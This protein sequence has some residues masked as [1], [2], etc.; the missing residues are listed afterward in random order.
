MRST[1]GLLMAVEVVNG[2]GALAGGVSL[3]VRPDGAIMHMPT[4]YLAGSPFADYFVPGLLLALVVGV[5][6]LGAALLLLL[7]R[8]YAT[9]AAIIT[10]GALV[11][12]EIVEFSI[13]GFNA[14]QVVFG[15]LGAIVFVLATQR[16]LADRRPRPRA[17]RQ[18]PR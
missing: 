15:L 14:L 5:G 9:E 3:M 10:G 16:W 6:M 2:L 12:F 7:R 4:T 18:V 17:L 13:I 8:P 11:I 1:R